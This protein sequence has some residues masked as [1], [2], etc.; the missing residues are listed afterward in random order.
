LLL[1]RL[2]PERFG[3]PLD[4][5]AATARAAEL[6]EAVAAGCDER[7]TAEELLGG[8]LRIA[9]ERM[10][11]AMRRVSI[12]RGF[13]PA[14]HALLA[15]GGA[16]GQHACALAELLDIRTVLVPP[17]AALLSALGLGAARLERFAERQVLAPL[18][19][20]R[21][22]MP[23]WL[24]ELTAS[25]REELLAEGCARAEIAAPRCLASLRLVGQ[26]STLELEVGSEGELE[27]AFRARYRERYGYAA[28]ERPIE[29]ESL[30]VVVATEAPLSPAAVPVAPRRVAAEVRRRA[31]FAGGWREAEFWDRESLAPGDALDG[32]GLVFEAHSATLIEEGWRAQVDGAGALVLTR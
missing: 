12:R 1:G 7:L 19:A 8:L 17:D 15:F 4:A 10:A 18:A 24:A 9:D 14:D 31:W 29:L 27:A 26:E 23:G 30:R 28:E 5:A 32:P 2:A 6:A 20:V 16:G 25:A 11:E 21:T 3:I 22:Q 13:L